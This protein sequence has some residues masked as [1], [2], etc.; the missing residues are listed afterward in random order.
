M[1][2]AFERIVRTDAIKVLAQA[3]QVRLDIAGDAL[4]QILETL[5]RLNRRIDDHFPAQ[6]YPRDFFQKPEGKPGAEGEAV[7]L[8]RAA[9]GEADL[10]RLFQQRP[11]GNH[12]EINRRGERMLVLNAHQADGERWHPDLEVAHIE[13]AGTA[14]PAVTCSG[15]MRSSSS[16]ARHSRLINPETRM[17]EIMV[18]RM[19]NSRLLADTTAAA[20]TRITASVKSTPPLVIR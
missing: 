7:F 10:N 3:L 13:R 4:Q 2:R 18:A 11:A 9:A 17:V 20:P 1:A 6:C 16:P 12:G 5:M 19:R 15:M 8:I 14:R